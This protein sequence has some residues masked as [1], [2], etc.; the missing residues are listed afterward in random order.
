M[1]SCAGSR[2]R[3]RSG[4]RE[5]SPSQQHASNG[6]TAAAEAE[7]APTAN[8]DA[9]IDL[10]SEHKPPAESHATANGLCTAADPV[11]SP[12]GEPHITNCICRVSRCRKFACMQRAVA[13]KASCSCCTHQRNHLLTEILCCKQGI[14]ACQLLHHVLATALLPEH[15]TCSCC[16]HIRQ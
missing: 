7:A 4:S 1:A 12:A 8:G 6:F 9:V 14:C 2:S 15:C 10:A 3:S 5:V 11:H 13:I 16:S